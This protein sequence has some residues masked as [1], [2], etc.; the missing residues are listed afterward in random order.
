M[1]LEAEVL[2]HVE[3][4]VARA[5]LQP[6]AKEKLMALAREVCALKVS[7]GGAGCGVG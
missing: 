5:L 4:E 1:Q 6:E 3:V 7:S 2:Q